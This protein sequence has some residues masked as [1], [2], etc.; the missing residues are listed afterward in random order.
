MKQ[1]ELKALKC[2]ISDL[3]WKLCLACVFLLVG[4]TQVFGI[5]QVS[6]NAMN[7]ALK[8]GDLVLYYRIRPTPSS[9]E[10]AAVAVSGSTEI[11]RTVAQAGDTVDIQPDGLFING[12]LQQEPGITSET[13]P[14]KD[15]ITFPVTL[16]EGQ[17]FVLADV[18][19]DSEDSRI[20][21]P[22]DSSAVKG[23]V[24]TVIRRRGF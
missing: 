22:V 19:T 16:Q 18:R 4:F 14:L 5:L 13:L 20:Y 2:V 1:S 9:H 15:G 24:I 12:Y 6:D 11:R 3:F 23:R 21:G 17:I 8:E 10:L 7:P